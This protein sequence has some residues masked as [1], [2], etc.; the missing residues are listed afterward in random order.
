M[1]QQRP[2]NEQG[3]TMPR[4][5]VHHNQLTLPEE[6]RQ[7]VH[8]SDD[9]YVEAEVVEKGILLRPSPE[10]RRRRALAGI[11]EAQASVRYTGPEP[12]PSAEEEEERIAQ[13]L[14]EEKAEAR[15]SRDL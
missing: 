15:G 12:R 3:S 5:S 10:A 9:D 1:Y 14:A 11:R 6:L 7:A 2:D 8:L 13:M 4:V